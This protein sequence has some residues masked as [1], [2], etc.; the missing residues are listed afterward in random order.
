MAAGAE[1]GN[2]DAV[3]L[4]K[5]LGVPSRFEPAHSP[6]PFARRLMSSRPGCLDTDVVDEQSRAAQSVSPPRSCAVC[7]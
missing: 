2:D 6:F 5:T 3:H 7:Q 4:D 1:V